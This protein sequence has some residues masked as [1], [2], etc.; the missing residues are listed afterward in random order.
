[1]VATHLGTACLLAMFVLLADAAGSFDFDDLGRAAEGKA[2]PERLALERRG[3]LGQMRTAAAEI[4]T[5]REQVAFGQLVQH[6]LNPSTPDRNVVGD[7]PGHVV[8]AFLEH[9]L[10]VVELHLLRS[11]ERQVHPVRDRLGEGAAAQGEH[12][13]PLDAAVPD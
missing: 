1:M 12:A 9:A 13:R 10:G 2:L 7:D 8:H 3:D 11:R 5:A 4:D 6:Q